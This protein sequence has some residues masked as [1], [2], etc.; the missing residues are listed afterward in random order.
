M[1]VICGVTLAACNFVKL[2]ALDMHVFHTPGLTVPVAMVI[3]LTM[4]F[5]VICAKTVGCLLPLLA[6]K[7]HLDPAVMASP[8]IST[9]VDVLTLVIYFQVARH[10]LQI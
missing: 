2:L 5:T 6:E 7:I 4:I 1:A 3:C 10:I 9:I 8:F